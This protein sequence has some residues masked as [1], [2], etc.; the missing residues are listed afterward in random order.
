MYIE[1]FAVPEIRIRNRNPEMGIDNGSPTNNNNNKCK[2]VG[3]GC[4]RGAVGQSGV[5]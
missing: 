4:Q 2:Q 5:K 3:A 1:V